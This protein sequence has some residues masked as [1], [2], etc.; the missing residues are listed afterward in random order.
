MPVADLKARLRGQALARR[1][2][3]SLAE[4]QAF[5]AN[6][7]I[8]ALQFIQSIPG[9]PIISAYWPINDEADTRPM[10]K[11][12]AQAGFATA[13]PVTGA[14]GTALVFRLWQPGDPQVKGQ[15]AIPEPAP[16][17]PL[18]EPDILFV[19]LAAFDRRGHRIG[20]GAGH[21]DCTLAQL[22]AKKPV[23]AIGIAYYEQE[24]AEVPA[25]SHD[26]RLDFVL[27]PRQLI[28][29]RTP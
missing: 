21:Y 10:L 4:R 24:I 3:L 5:A 23:L 14:R 29:C 26:A 25:Q 12:L 17:L 19:P 28:D 8:S 13:L 18:A 2:A 9:R 6:L 7:A 15:L 11:A 1:S 20:Y 22:R 16:H 27:T